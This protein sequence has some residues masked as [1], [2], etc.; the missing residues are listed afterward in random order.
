[1]SGGVNSVSNGSERYRI[2][3]ELAIRVHGLQKL[4]RPE[5]QR[6]FCQV[7]LHASAEPFVHGPRNGV[8]PL[9]ACFEHEATGEL[10]I[11]TQFGHETSREQANQAVLE[12]AW[13]GVLPPASVRLLS[14]GEERARLHHRAVS[15]KAHGITQMLPRIVPHGPRSSSPPAPPPVVSIS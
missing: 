11:V 6:R 4:R 14:P 10:G 12:D 7:A 8:V 5:V 13:L 2:E 9:H 1:L 15:A 3:E